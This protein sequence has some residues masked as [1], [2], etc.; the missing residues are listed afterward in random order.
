ME[1]AGTVGALLDNARL[2]AVFSSALALRYDLRLGRFLFRPPGATVEMVLTDAQLLALLAKSL[3]QHPGLFPALE[4]QPRQ[5]KR[6]VDMFKAHCARASDPIPD[7]QQFIAARLVH[8]PGCDVTSSELFTA[9]TAFI[10]DHGGLG[11]S[12]Y[13]FHRTLPTIIKDRF[14][15]AKRHEI[16]RPGPT[17]RFTKRNGWRGVKLTD[18]TD[19]TD[20]TDANDSTRKNS[21]NHIPE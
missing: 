19:G 13:E 8:E 18:G 14:G 9:Y 7:L 11:L 3:A 10:G 5:Q 20:G 4:I 21:S 15:I 17:G 16:L 2:C 6:L 12:A 1:T